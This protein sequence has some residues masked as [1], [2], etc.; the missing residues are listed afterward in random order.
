MSVTVAE[1]RISVAAGDPGRPTE[2]RAGE[3]IAF[4]RDGRLSAIEPADVAAA[5]QWLS[6]KLSFRATP[7]GEVLEEV[8][9]YHEAELLLPDP[10]LR[11]LAVTG[12]FDPR[13][14][15][16]FLANIEAMLSLEAHRIGGGT[17]VLD[18]DFGA[19]P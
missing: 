5:T 2:L 13:D 1:G 16:R 6:G 8:A 17:V 12:T 14:L 10:R 19:T 11:Q 3:R 18:R 4:G 9:R 15:D 7:L